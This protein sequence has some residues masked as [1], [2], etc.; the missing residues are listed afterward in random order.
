HSDARSDAEPGK[1]LHEMR[2]GEMAGLGEVPFGCYYGSVDSTPL[3][4]MLA[5]DYVARTGDVT[6]ARALWPNVLRAL[7][8]MEGPGDLDGD[9]F[10]EY[11]RRS[12][13]GLT[14]QGWKDSGDSV[15]HA[16]GTSAEGP[17]ALCE[18]QGYVFAAY[19]A[20]SRLAAML[21][22]RARADAYAARAS[23]LQTQFER[24]FWCEDLGT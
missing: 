4:V 13:K 7:T 9:G 1:I 5:G 19:R 10:V 15:F 21:D 17:I 8:W 14:Q 11:F 6:F 3:F 24:A 23:T 12:P 2:G 20:A 18:V 22:D 16:D